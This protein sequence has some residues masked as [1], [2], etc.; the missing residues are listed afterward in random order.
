MPSKRRIVSG[1]RP[2]Q[3][4]PSHQRYRPKTHAYTT[5]VA[6][7]SR[8]RRRGERVAIKFTSRWGNKHKGGHSSFSWPAKM[9]GYTSKPCIRCPTIYT[10]NDVVGLLVSVCCLRLL[11]MSYSHKGT[12]TN[13][14]PTKRTKSEIGDVE[15]NR[16]LF[17]SSAYG[18]NVEICAI[19][20]SRRED[21]INIAKRYAMQFSG[22]TVS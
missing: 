11:V 1:W 3:Q 2:A 14:K 15:A 13:N 18:T 10:S 20:D 8:T 12:N 4:C 22:R 16:L 17:A 6:N 7:M 9:R 21:A 19:R 5:I